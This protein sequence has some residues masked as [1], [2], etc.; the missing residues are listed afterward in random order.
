[1]SVATVRL[2]APWA[3]LG[4]SA[5]EVGPLLAADQLVPPPVPSAPFGGVA[6]VAA[7]VRIDI[8]SI[9]VHA[10]M[11][12]LHLQ[13]D[14]TLSVPKDFSA[15]GW[16]ADATLPSAIGPTVIAGHIDF[17]R[18]PAVFS[19]LR[20]LKPGAAVDVTRVDGTSALPAV[21]ALPETTPGV[22]EH[23]TIAGP[24]GALS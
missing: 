8:P 1:M 22:A 5:D 13:R 20:D 11:V 2:V 19:R 9:K 23:G 6:A 7:P 3:A 21:I 10:L 14:G 18:A 15:A 16:W 12:E 17:R 24:A 4:A